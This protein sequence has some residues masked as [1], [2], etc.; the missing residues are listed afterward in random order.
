MSS[1]NMVRV[2]VSMPATLRDRL[3]VLALRNRRAE[4]GVTRDAVI[5]RACGEW[6]EGQSSVRID[7]AC[8]H[9]K[10]GGR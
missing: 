1:N 5:V 4:P 10:R 6:L 8:S 9:S 2:T 7:S 3:D